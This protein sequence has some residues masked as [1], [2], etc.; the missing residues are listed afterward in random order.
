MFSPILELASYC[1]LLR[2][3]SSMAQ[4][5]ERTGTFFKNCGIGQKTGVYV[6][7]EIIPSF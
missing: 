2:I 7:K 5:N 6:C 4:R 1:T 3:K